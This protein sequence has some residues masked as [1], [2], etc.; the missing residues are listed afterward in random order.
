MLG[1]TLFINGGMQLDIFNLTNDTKKRLRDKFMDFQRKRLLLHSMID[2]YVADFM[3]SKCSLT[4]IYETLRQKFSP[5]ISTLNHLICNSNGS[6]LW[7]VPD[8][9]IL[10]GKQRTSI[11][12]T[13]IKLEL[14]EEWRI[15]LLPIRRRVK[16]ANGDN[17]YAY[18]QE[19]F[20]LFFDRYEEEYLQRFLHPR[21]C[22]PGNS[23]DE[24]EIR[25]F[26][27]HLKS[28]ATNHSSSHFTLKHSSCEVTLLNTLP[29]T[30]SN[31]LSLFWEKAFDI[32]I[33]TIIPIV[34]SICLKLS[35]TWTTLAS[36]FSVSPLV[37]IAT[38]AFAIRTN[39]L[40]HNLFI[41]LG[42][43][44]LLFTLLWYSK[45]F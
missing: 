45:T 6:V 43:G 20:D 1:A 27:L 40:T 21:R 30:W 29:L 9:A 36:C 24:F 14:S 11:T 39:R 35:K 23:S 34:V 32:R 17:I 15:R 42:A 7:T 10:L 8:I 13:L 26:W 19:I 38:S 28:N 44:A 3:N 18:S 37:I 31:I 25:R 4:H 16:A 22:N 41:N 5:K 2:V 12:R 33:F